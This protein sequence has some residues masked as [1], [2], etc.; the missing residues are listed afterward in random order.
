MAK[1]RITESGNVKLT[2]SIEQFNVLNAICSNVRMGNT[3][4]L[5]NE[6]SQLMIDIE[7][8]LGTWEYNDEYE[9]VRVTASIVDINCEVI[10]NLE[11]NFCIEIE[12]VY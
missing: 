5:R 7:R 4:P 1:A 10:A 12:E 6:F 8:D 2:M 9:E 3:N 11:D